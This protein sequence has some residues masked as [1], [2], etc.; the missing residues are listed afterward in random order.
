MP[1]SEKT[2]G[3][4]LDELCGEEVRLW[5]E[6]NGIGIAAKD[7][8]R[9]FG[10]FERVHPEKTYEG[11][12][13]GLSI[14]RKGTERMNGQSGVESEADHGSRFWIQLRAA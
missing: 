2:G 11:T 7:L 13:I 14:V 10:I 8:D 3:E 6:D 5:I 1:P 4:S 12:G 9:I